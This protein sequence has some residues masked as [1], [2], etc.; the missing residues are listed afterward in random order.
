M[1]LAIIIYLLAA[2]HIFIGE[3]VA[4]PSTMTWWQ[5]AIWSLGWLAFLI[6]VLIAT[7]FEW[8][9]GKL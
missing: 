8:I 5:A 4:Q 9:R 2:L 7:G 1:T 6:F 3:Y